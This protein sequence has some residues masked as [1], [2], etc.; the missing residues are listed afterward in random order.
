MAG[1][2]RSN[3]TDTGVSVLVCLDV[4][5]VLGVSVQTRVESCARRRGE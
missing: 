1:E 3:N 5:T 2:H 4:D